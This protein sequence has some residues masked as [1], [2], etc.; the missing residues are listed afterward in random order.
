M[1]VDILTIGSAWVKCDFVLCTEGT[2]SQKFI[3]ISSFANWSKSHILCLWRS[4]IIV[5]SL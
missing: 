4:L 3:W 5:P 2:Y 1:V